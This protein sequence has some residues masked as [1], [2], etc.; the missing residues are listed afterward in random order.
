M[1]TQKIV[2]SQ[3]IYLWDPKVLPAGSQARSHDSDN[4]SQHGIP[5]ILLPGHVTCTWDPNS[6]H[7]LCLTVADGIPRKF[8]LG[9]VIYLWDPTVF[10][11][12][13]PGQVTCSG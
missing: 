2:S 7:M 13:I 8:V 1:A 9:Q 10:V 6:D 12:G 3:V 4:L 5:E 11:Y